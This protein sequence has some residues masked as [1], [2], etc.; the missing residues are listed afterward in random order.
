V[1]FS[2]IWMVTR[3]WLRAIGVLLKCPASVEKLKPTKSKGLM[4]TQGE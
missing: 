3:G 4:L 1:F 2:T